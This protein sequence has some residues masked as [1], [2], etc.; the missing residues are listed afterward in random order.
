MRQK[1][2]E[3]GPADWRRIHKTRAKL[4][5][6]AQINVEGQASTS[7]FSLKEVKKQRQPIFNLL[8]KRAKILFRND[9]SVDFQQR[10]L[11]WLRKT[12][13]VDIYQPR[14]K[15]QTIKVMPNESG[16]KCF[17]SSLSPHFIK[18]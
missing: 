9:Y 1:F 8:S 17:C 5:E 6:T 2:D 13:P 12:A 14:I 3:R 18:R 7:C 10:S 15:A 4:V 11:G 16:K